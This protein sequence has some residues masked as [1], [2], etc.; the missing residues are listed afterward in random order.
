M[1]VVPSA[2]LG[3]APAAAAAAAISAMLSF[4]PLFFPRIRY[5]AKWLR[6]SGIACLASSS[7]I[8]PSWAGWKLSPRCPSAAHAVQ[9]V[10]CHVAARPV[11]VPPAELVCIGLHVR[12]GE[13]MEGPFD[14]G[15]GSVEKVGV[16]ARSARAGSPS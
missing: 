4:G 10:G 9:E 15:P 2:N 5:S 14:A 1:L 8:E 6:T 11:A 3:I 13:P 12:R 16:E 7:S